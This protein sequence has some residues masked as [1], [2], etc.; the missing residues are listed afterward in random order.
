M[1]VMNIGKLEKENEG[2]RLLMKIQSGVCNDHP[3]LT[4]EQAEVKLAVTSVSR[5]RGSRLL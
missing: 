3:G 5:V 4:D 1:S 2:V